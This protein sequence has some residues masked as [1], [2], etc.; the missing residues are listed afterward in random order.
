MIHGCFGGRVSP[1]LDQYRTIIV[2]RTFPR[3]G[4]LPIPESLAIK[5]RLFGLAARSSL[6]SY[7][8]SRLELLPGV[9]ENFSFACWMYRQFSCSMYWYAHAAT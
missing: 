9:E 2:V 5:Q 6:A 1:K 7:V 3:A 8:V 4:L